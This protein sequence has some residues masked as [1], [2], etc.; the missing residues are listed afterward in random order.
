MDN[1]LTIADKT[2]RPGTQTATEKARFKFPDSR[3]RFILAAMTLS[4]VE[5]C[6]KR[7]MPVDRRALDANCKSVARW[8]TDPGTKQSLIMTGYPGTGKTTMLDALAATLKQLSVPSH[9]FNA[10]DLP[11]HMLG[12]PE[13]YRERVLQGKWMDYLLIDDV[14]EEPVYVMDYGR[15]LPLFS[16]IVAERYARMLPVVITTNLTLNQIQSVYGERTA[17]R[18]HEV[19]DV[20]TFKGSSYRI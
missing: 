14:G 8:L 15:Q 9:R 13:L 4:A 1:L 19:A 17:D 20:L 6:T 16:K 2:F 12:S 10:T 5:Q 7:G 3:R 18:L 11:D